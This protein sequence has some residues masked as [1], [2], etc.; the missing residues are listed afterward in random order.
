MIPLQANSHHAHEQLHCRLIA[1]RDPN[2][3]HE[4]LHGYRNK[5]LRSIM[6]QL[7][8]QVDYR[9]FCQVN[10]IVLRIEGWATSVSRRL[11][12]RWSYPGKCLLGT[13]PF[14]PNLLHRESSKD[15]G[16]RFIDI[17]MES[18]V[19]G[20][21]LEVNFGRGISFGYERSNVS[22]LYNISSLVYSLMHSP[23]RVESDSS[24]CS[25]CMLPPESPKP[26]WMERWWPR[27]ETWD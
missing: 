19:S 21:Q 26:R 15:Y 10:H 5:C 12:H 13:R 8:Y 14:L 25:A 4:L 27:K 2:Q 6:H 1:H 20:T 23:C 3:R 18:A 11:L 17:A 24:I 7:W 22:G 16:V 9:L